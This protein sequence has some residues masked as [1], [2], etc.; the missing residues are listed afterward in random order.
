[1]HYVTIKSKTLICYFNQN[2]SVRPFV[3]PS[4]HLSLLGT[5]WP[6]WL[7]NDQKGYEMTWV[8]IDHHIIISYPADLGTKWPKWVRNDLGTKWLLLGTKWP[9]SRYEMTKVGMKW[10]GY[11][12]TGNP[13][14]LDIHSIENVKRLYRTLISQL[15]PW[16]SYCMYLKEWKLF[17]TSIICRGRPW[18]GWPILT[19][20]KIG[21]RVLVYNSNF[22]YIVLFA[23]LAGEKV[24]RIDK[25][26]EQD[27]RNY[28]PS[29]DS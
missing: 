15:K 29:A 9:K 20:L 13:V 19:V 10:P 16:K 3:S 17:I 21:P 8:R 12:M 2:T 1:M 23:W 28:F 7:R 18:Q 6:K 26:N 14:D 24:L 22:S 11:E 5:K 25:F 4:I 27:S